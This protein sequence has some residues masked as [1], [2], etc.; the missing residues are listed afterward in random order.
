MLYIAQKSCVF[1]GQIQ[2]PANGIR[3]Y[4]NKVRLRGLKKGESLL[5]LRRME[6]ATTHTKSA[7]AD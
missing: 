6:F 4:R 5:N 7:S 1:S 2:F 3:D